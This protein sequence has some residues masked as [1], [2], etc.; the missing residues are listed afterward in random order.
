MVLFYFVKKSRK[1]LPVL[2]FF[3]KHILWYT[4]FKGIYERRCMRMVMKIP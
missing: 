1:I 2:V 3:M 4:L